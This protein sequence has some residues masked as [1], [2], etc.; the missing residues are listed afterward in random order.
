MAAPQ[1]ILDALESVVDIYFSGVRHRERAAFIL[2]DNLVEMACKTKARQH[3]Y[4]FDTACGF[5]TA[6]N[7]PGCEIDQEL[8]DR[9]Q[10]YRNT[11]N[12]MQHATAAGTVDSRHCADAIIDAIRVIDS[13]WIN[14]S[15][16]QFPAWLTCSVRVIRY[17]SSADESG[18]PPYEFE[19]RMRET[20]WRGSKENL[21]PNE[22]EMR[23]GIRD[24]WGFA[25]KMRTYQVEQ[26]LNELGIP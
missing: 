21:A 2:C 5:H 16:E 19:D 20:P 18:V 7:A 4:Q 8:R 22:V 11:R 26:C 25:I 9:V 3:D 17:Y 15:E 1:E 23:P 13:L 12:N 6:L 10:N 24:H 14:T